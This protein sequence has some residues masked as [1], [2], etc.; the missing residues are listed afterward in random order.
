M[1]GV[2]LA[3]CVAVLLLQDG[4]YPIQAAQLRRMAKKRFLKNGQNIL[5]SE[6]AR[7][8]AGWNHD[9]EAHTSIQEN[10]EV[11]N[12]KPEHVHW[13]SKAVTFVQQ[14]SPED[15]TAGMP[16][17]FDE[18]KNKI[19]G[20]RGPLERPFAKVPLRALLVGPL[21]WPF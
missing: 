3:A 9:E 8:P 21:Y 18:K 4:V 17:W 14:N 1:L 10:D 12:E 15:V 5:S 2:A 20:C 19:E 7:F 6:N 16:S 13:D 11:K